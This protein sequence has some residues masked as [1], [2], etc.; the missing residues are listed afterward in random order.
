MAFS[1]SIIAP[2]LIALYVMKAASLYEVDQK[3]EKE[4]NE[5]IK[6]FCINNLENIETTLKHNLCFLQ[7]GIIGF[8]GGSIL[9]QLFEMKFVK[10]NLSYSLWNQT[11]TLKTICR[12]I[13]SAF[14]YLMTSLPYFLVKT[15]VPLV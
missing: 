15:N 9:G 11:T 13:L 14:F 7:S 2:I 10:I 8:A 5:R 4:I 3:L 1:I 12:L 6:Y